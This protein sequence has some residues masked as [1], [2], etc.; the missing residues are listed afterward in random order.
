M[1]ATLTLRRSVPVSLPA[2][3]MIGSV[4]LGGFV[5]GLV[6][7]SAARAPRAVL[8]PSVEQV[9]FERLVASNTVTPID[10]TLDAPLDAVASPGVA[11]VVYAKGSATALLDPRT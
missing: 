10:S 2:W 1:F 6:L 11:A 5:G 9:A 4:A 7:V 8:T 3:G